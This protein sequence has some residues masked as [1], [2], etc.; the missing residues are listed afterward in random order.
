MAF[1]RAGKTT[2]LESLWMGVPVITLAG[3]AHLGRVGVSFLTAVGFEELVADDASDYAA[4]AIELA[5]DIPRLRML[6]S[7]LR[8]RMQSSPLTDAAGYARAIEQVYQR[9]I[10]HAVASAPG[11]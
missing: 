1:P 9:L 11:R 6:R 5:L 10:N 4:K 7:E 8:P 2:T 3:E